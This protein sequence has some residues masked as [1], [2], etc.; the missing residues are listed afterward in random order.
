MNMAKKRKTT[1]NAVRILHKRYIK[2][3][4]KRLKSLKA[5]REK[6]NIAEQIYS[7]R[8]QAGLSQKEFAKLVG[9]TQS[10]ISRLE[11]ADYGRHSL[12]MLHRIATAM[13]CKVEV[14]LVPENG[15][16]AYA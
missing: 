1:T 8:T 13:H 11:N 16:Y 14:R 5:E 4:P 2:N 6:S 9:T 10:V 3:D 15:D 12:R 7:L